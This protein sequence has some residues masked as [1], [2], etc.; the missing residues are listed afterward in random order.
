[1][2]P[3][4]KCLLV[5]VVVN[6]YNGEQYLAQ[7]V[8]SICAQTYENLEIIL[9]DDGSSDRCPEICKRY[10]ERDVRIKAV[11]KEANAGLANARKTG[12]LTSSG[13]YVFYVDG[14]DWVEIK[15]VE[16]MV[17][18]AIR[19]KADMVIAGHKEELSG[20]VV[21]ILENNLSPG[22]Y[23]REKLI[24]EV[25]PIMLNTGK[26][27]QFGIFTYIWGKLFRRDLLLKNLMDIDERI[28]IGEDAACVYPCLLGSDT[29]C[30]M[31]EAYYH[32]RQRVDSSVKTR[33]DARF[34]TQQLDI[35]YR[36]LKTKFLRSQ[37]AELLLPQLDFFLLSLL[38]VRSDGFLVN[39]TQNELFPFSN[40][41]AGS[42]IVVCGAGTFGQHLYRRLQASQNYHVTGWI[43]DLGSEY[44]SLG[45]EVDDVSCVCDMSYDHIV[46]AFIDEM[47]AD[48]VAKKLIKLGVPANKIARVSHYEGDVSRLL[49]ESGIGREHEQITNK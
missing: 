5:S 42:E 2:S 43:D 7:C 16:E 33:K 18:P 15:M 10:E 27:S 14:D 20:Q 13:E 48:K 34:D 31:S 36:Y 38:T 23:D 40:V 11:C 30:V 37:H 26:F 46:I 21:E 6:I 35:L 45:I 22:V 28:F 1:M 32:Y 25:F 8:D 3:N 19:S 9:V 12:L 41:G 17:G 39:G 44:T 24:K 47:V 4:K 29:I 49:T